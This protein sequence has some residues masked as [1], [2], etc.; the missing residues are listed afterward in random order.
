MVGRYDQAFG[1]L[2]RTV[3]DESY[4]AVDLGLNVITAFST[5]GDSVEGISIMVRVNRVP[6]EE[7]M[8]NQPLGFE[9]IDHAMRAER[10][11]L[12]LGVDEIHV[13]VAHD[14]GKRAP[15]FTDTAVR[16]VRRKVVES[17]CTAVRMYMS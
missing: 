5:L 1:V 15:S 10:G 16:V 17:T 2:I 6:V 14:E 9:S 13:S 11:S 3:F 8:P 4:S 12:H 7:V